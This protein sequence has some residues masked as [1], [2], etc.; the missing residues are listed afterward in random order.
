M[1]PSEIV[2]PIDFENWALRYLG[3][4]AREIAAMR[5]LTTGAIQARNKEF[6]ALVEEFL[7]DVDL[8]SVNARARSSFELDRAFPGHFLRLCRILGLDPP[9]NR[10]LGRA[11]VFGHWAPVRAQPDDTAM[12]RHYSDLAVGSDIHDVGAVLERFLDERA[13]SAIRSAFDQLDERGREAASVSLSA[14]VQ[15]FADFAFSLEWVE[16]SVA[17]A[18]LQMGFLGEIRD[19]RSILIDHL[20]GS[21]VTKRAAYLSLARIEPGRREWIMKAAHLV[22]NRAH[23]EAA[24]IYMAGYAGGL[25]ICAGKLVD[26]YGGQTDMRPD[27]PDALE[28][29]AGQIESL[30]AERP[31]GLAHLLAH[32]RMRPGI[33][34][35]NPRAA[36]KVRRA[37]AVANADIAVPVDTLDLL[38]KVNREVQSQY[39]DKAIDATV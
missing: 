26:R 32:L 39:E 27:F 14:I 6:Y 13:T 9:P 19:V 3:R 7:P 5:S 34:Q 38:G 2:N 28:W 37:L 31:L 24:F 18:L 17:Q 8:P 20:E 25:R 33:L 30:P 36:E 23:I 15:R 22:S 21:F 4:T 35:R 11:S 1:L 12:A 10:E 16:I 29:I